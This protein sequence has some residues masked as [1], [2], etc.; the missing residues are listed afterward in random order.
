MAIDGG[1]DEV[2]QTTSSFFSKF[3]NDQQP[4]PVSQSVQLIHF[5][6]MIFAPLRPTANQLCTSVLIL[7]IIVYQFHVYGYS[8]FV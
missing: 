1:C 6:F 2:K 4:K 5:Q 7:H 3:V 8:H